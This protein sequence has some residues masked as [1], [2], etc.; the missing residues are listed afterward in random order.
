MPEPPQS[1]STGTRSLIGRLLR[2]PLVHFL[3]IGSLVFAFQAWRGAARPAAAAHAD[4]V[5]TPAR[6][7][8]LAANFER[9]WMRAP[10]PAELQGLVH[11][12]VTEE[13]MVREALRLGLDRDDPVIRHRLRQKMEF[14]VDA[15]TE[16]LRP[17]DADLR[18]WLLSHAAAYRTEARYSFEQIPFDAARR[19]ARAE[20][21]ARRGLAAL[22]QGATRVAGD[23]LPLLESHYVDLPAGELERSF[24]AEFAARMAQ[25]PLGAW[26]GPVVSGYGL[27][28]VRIES[29]TAPQTARLDAVR[30]LVERDWLSARR[31]QFA[32]ARLA[33]LERPYRIVLPAAVSAASAPPP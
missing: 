6:V 23:A 14:I 5:V 22:R 32:E 13:V 24:G 2:E 33:E 21:D 1:P 17:S 18:A 3:L 9:T 15:A 7:S 30:P 31:K 8:N 11:D 19:G 4:I 27:H 12:H 25:L 26:V 10:T 28:L 16:Q 20:A 29:R